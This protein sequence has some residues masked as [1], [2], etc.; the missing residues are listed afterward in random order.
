MSIDILQDKIRKKKN[1]SIILFE[2]FPELIPQ[3]ILQEHACFA[4]AVEKYFCILLEGLKD[5]VPA[6]RFGFS[7]F[8]I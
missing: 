3:Q 4:D 8:V 1:P 6:V 5:T 7:S 2:V